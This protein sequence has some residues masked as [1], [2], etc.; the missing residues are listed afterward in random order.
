M[1]ILECTVDAR[2]PIIAQDGGGTMHKQKSEAFIQLSEAIRREILVRMNHCNLDQKTVA[3]RAD[4]TETTATR[5]L[6]LHKP[7]A[8]LKLST[9]FAIAD[10][11]DL[12]V[13]VNFFGKIADT[14]GGKNR[15]KRTARP[16]R[17]TRDTKRRL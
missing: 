16:H 1:G 9:L 13:K 12:E 14:S 11:V 17:C 3:R 5:I 6:S 15:R 7:P 10:A 8:D 2:I 4:I